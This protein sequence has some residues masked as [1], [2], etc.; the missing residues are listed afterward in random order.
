MQMGLSAATCSKLR[1]Y[2]DASRVRLKAAES[3]VAQH[4]PRAAR[5]GQQANIAS[6]LLR[7]L[8]LLPGPLE[9]SPRRASLHRT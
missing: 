6:G 4:S 1:I 9:Q 2:G 5:E 7:G 8:Y 3:G